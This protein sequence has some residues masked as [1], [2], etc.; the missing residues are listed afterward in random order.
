MGRPLAARLSRALVGC[1][2]RRW[3][4][5]YGEELL[6]VLDQHRPGVRTV[7][8]LGAGTLGTHLDP[9]YRMEG[10]A[11]IGR[12]KKV[13][14]AAAAGTSVLMMLALLVGFAAWQENKGPPPGR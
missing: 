2:P 13:L 1:Y 8:D 4:Q 6:D 11:M 7:L 10:L 14:A 9:V 5:R 3:R 12:H